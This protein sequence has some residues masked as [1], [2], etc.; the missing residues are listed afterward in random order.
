MELKVFDRLMLLNILPTEGNFL[1]LKIVTQLRQ[2]LSF[3]EEELKRFE[4]VQDG[5]SVTWNRIADEPKEVAIG[6][7]ATDII[8]EAL[9]KLNDTKKL[10]MQHYKL[11]E[12]F[13]EG[14]K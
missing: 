11:Y 14:G 2:D 12:R 3:T 6:E 13:I 10:T 5:G 1:T 9:K 4:I 8:V 7:K